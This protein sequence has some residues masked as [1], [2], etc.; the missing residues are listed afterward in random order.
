MQVI[1]TNSFATQVIESAREQ[2]HGTLQDCSQKK[3]TSVW[4]NCSM[5]QR[6]R[7]CSQRFCKLWSLFIFTNLKL[8]FCRDVVY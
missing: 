2:P 4:R 7:A 8:Q 3:V 6:P 1:D 5:G